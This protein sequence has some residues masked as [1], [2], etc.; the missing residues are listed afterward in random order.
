MVLGL[1]RRRRRRNSAP[2]QAISQVEASGR[3]K[4]ERSTRLRRL[5][6]LK[7]TFLVVL[8]TGQ[9]ENGVREPHN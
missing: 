6:M 1:W 4:K 9:L 5:R 2:E 7:N 3:R 8:K